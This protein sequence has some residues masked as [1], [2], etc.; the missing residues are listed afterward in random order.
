MKYAL[1]VLRD[2]RRPL[3]QEGYPSVVDA[4]LTGG[5]ELNEI[6]LCSLSNGRDVTSHLTRLKEEC[7][8]VFLTCQEEVLG[9]AKDLL[10]AIGIGGSGVVFEREECLFAL[11][12]ETKKG[13]ETVA[14]EVI[15]AVDRKR[16]RRYS[17]IAVRAV[18]PP[19]EK[20]NALVEQAKRMSGEKLSFSVW[21][22]YGDTRIE[23]VYDSETPKMLV[24]DVTR[25]FVS[26]LDEY[27]Y[28]VDDTPLAQR[29]CDALGLHRL[30]LSTAE[31]FTGGGVGRAIVSIS[32]A[33]KVFFEGLN[34]YA[35]ESKT[36]RTGV[37]LL[38][39]KA[40]GAVSD[41]VAY[42]MAA[43]LIGQG[44]CDVSV[45]TTG[46]A[47][48]KSDGTNKP[49]GL[50]YIAVGTKERVRVYRFHLEGDRETIT[51]T[52]VNLALFLV[53]KEIK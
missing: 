5:V 17:H 36:E 23:I 50:C 26:Q 24:D 12:P 15:P 49:V 13:I 32:G 34:T 39:L 18:M 48:P 35:N 29:V 43:G 2:G 9:Y 4:F 10:F 6:L 53:Y 33:S 16:K 11:F 27:V 28:S 42:E 22:R 41:G 52:A 20:V 30:V 19:S 21:E 45:A 14:L 38:T 3:C 40:E 51:E 47:G 31:S 25:L 46:I 1:I 7:D 8:G 37:S 44:R